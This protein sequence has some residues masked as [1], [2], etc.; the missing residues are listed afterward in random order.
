MILPSAL[1]LH[2]AHWLAQP[3]GR[4]PLF[5]YGVQ[6]GIDHG[7][8]GGLWFSA[9]LFVWYADLP[10]QQEVRLREFLRAVAAGIIAA[11]LSVA[12]SRLV[13]DV[14]PIHYPGLASR[15]PEYI[16]RLPLQNS[17]PSQST[18]VFFATALA[19]FAF[20]KWVGILLILV[21]FGLGSLPRMY[22]GGHFLVDVIAGAACGAAAYVVAVAAERWAPPLPARLRRGGNWYWIVTL[23]TFVYIIEFGSQFQEVIWF[24]RVLGVLKTGVLP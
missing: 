1:D 9:V 15:F 7:V 23:G 3:L 11:V 14:P 2:I 22:V 19:S 21:T 16:P 6:S 10:N 20:R 13:S 18:A 8:F 5:D 12:F 17:F 24:Q 4:N